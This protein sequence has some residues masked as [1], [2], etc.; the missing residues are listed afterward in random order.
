MDFEDLLEKY[1]KLLA[2]NKALIKENESLKARLGL[3]QKSESDQG[4]IAACNSPLELVAQE[5]P[6]ETPYPNRREQGVA[7]T[8]TGG[9]TPCSIITNSAEKISLFM[10]L[11][12]GRDDVYAKRWKH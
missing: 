3:N 8:H 11:F 7:T 10:S 12:K 9:K 5:S 6:S 1:H 4:Q 2:E